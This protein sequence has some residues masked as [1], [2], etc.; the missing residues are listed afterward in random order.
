MRAHHG[1]RVPP[2]ESDTVLLVDPRWW[3]C[4]LESLLRAIARRKPGDSSLR[5][6][7]LAGTPDEDARELQRVRDGQSILDDIGEQIKALT[8]RVG[9]ADRERLDL[10]LGSVREAKQ[11]L[12]QNE[13]WQ[14]TPKPKV[15]FPVPANDYGGAQLIERSRQC[16]TLFTWRCK[17]IR[18]AL[19][20]CG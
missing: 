12:Q 2:G 16:T 19:F 11:T 3:Q 20:P 1:S 14:T 18:R 9:R 10:F 5:N 17:P 13:R 6:L 7:F 15:D 4:R 8:R